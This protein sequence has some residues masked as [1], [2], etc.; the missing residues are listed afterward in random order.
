[1]VR[2]FSGPYVTTAVNVSPFA[3]RFSSFLLQNRY[4]GYLAAIKTLPSP[5]ESRFRLRRLLACT[6]GT[7]RGL[8]GSPPNRLKIIVKA[9]FIRS[10]S[11]AYFRLETVR[12]WY[13][14]L[15]WMLPPM[16]CRRFTVTS[17]NDTAGSVRVN[18]RFI[19]R[20]KSQKKWASNGCTWDSISGRIATPTTKSNLNPTS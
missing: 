7:K 17:M 19:R 13:A 14:F 12:T 8:S 4:G 6:T 3:Y 15:T 1:L 5:L 20:S 11:T 16:P 9:F 10:H 2:F 18:S